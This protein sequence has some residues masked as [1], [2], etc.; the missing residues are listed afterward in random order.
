ML[1]FLIKLVVKE[2]PESKMSTHEILQARK[3][4]KRQARYRGIYC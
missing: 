4:A 1:A 2:N 3:A